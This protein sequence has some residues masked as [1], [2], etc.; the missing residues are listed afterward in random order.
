MKLNIYA[1]E[2]DK[3]VTEMNQKL[4]QLYLE[5]SKSLESYLSELKKAM[6]DGAAQKMKQNN[7]SADNNYGMK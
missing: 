1:G 3:N 6:K 7:W 4:G 2:V 5:G